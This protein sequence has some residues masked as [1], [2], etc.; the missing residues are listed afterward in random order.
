M[1]QRKSCIIM[2]NKS[3]LFRFVLIMGIVNL[4]ADFTYEG[5]RSIVGPFLAV[6]GAS[7]FVV[8]F[9]GGFG[10]FL[11][12]AL[13]SVF[14]YVADK[15]GKYWATTLVGYAINL[16]AVPALALAGNWPL[17]AFLIVLERTGRAVRK[18]SVETM[19]SYTTG[20]LGKGWVFGLNEALDQVGATI[21]P[22]VVALVL[23]L[24]G[25]YR[26]SFALLLV[27]ALIC[28]GTL[29]VA[30]YFYPNQQNIGK[31]Q[32]K[33]Q[34]ARRFTR[35]YWIYVAAGS[36]LGAGFTSFSLISFHFQEAGTV[37]TPIIPVLYALAMGTGAITAL[38]F[39]RLLDKIGHVA[40]LAAF[41]A[42]AFFAPFVFIG[43]MNFAV[44]GMVLWGIGMGAQDSL[45]KAVITD[46]IPIERR[47][48]GFGLFDTGFGAF[49][50][51]GN[52]AMGLLYD[53]SI[54]ALIAFSI[55]LQLA[56]LPAFI[57]AKRAQ[58]K[59]VD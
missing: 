35:P 42:S 41:A 31:Q 7:G 32:A 28:I 12:Y 15:T 3:T 37:A 36:L 52:T 8:G 29:L 10:E 48:T 5:G 47:S 57:L 43:G 24:K 22:L 26:E 13:R 25:G 55:I 33:P 2:T 19:L 6:L 46:V 54:P 38:V 11:G 51:I 17:A 59:K 20:E 44:I 45:L 9:V 21:G 58:D 34:R 40:M 39:G 30:R 27:P 23:F 18:P 53:T 14:G 1:K 56:A 4:F 49:Y 16:F 50:L